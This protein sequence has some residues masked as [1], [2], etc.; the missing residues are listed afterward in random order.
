MKKIVV[1][2]EGQGELIFVRHILTQ[3]IG[4]E[5]LS[6][7]CFDLRAERLLT[8]PYKHNPPNAIIHYQIINVG[9]DEK[10]LSAI[11]ERYERFVNQGFEV[12]GLRDM[13][14][15]EY[16]KKSYQTDEKINDLIR[17]TVRNVINE[18]HDANRIH[19]FF[20][21]MELESWLLGIYENFERIDASL[22]ADYIRDSLGFDLR[23]INPET[24]FFQPAVQFGQVL[25]LANENYDKH[26]SEMEN[27]V[28]D[29]TLDDLNRLI[30][31]TRCASFALFFS[32]LQREF[33]EAHIGL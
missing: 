23:I 12:V 13:Y 22:T 18:L 15:S 5:Q 25:N 31:S 2:T 4:Y 9:T 20:A 11:L 17:N 14:S 3:L 10:V 33:R 21:V 7:E 24:E 29:I 6:F 1:F 32:E 19:F 28:R 26:K 30:N 8:V 27:I 16:K